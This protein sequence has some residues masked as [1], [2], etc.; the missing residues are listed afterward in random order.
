MHEIR[1]K[2]YIVQP[3]RLK[4]NCPKK[5]IRICMKFGTKVFSMALIR[6]KWFSKLS[7]ACKN[8]K[9]EL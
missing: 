8:A 4:K 6:N 3:A 1:R 2:I 7:D 5:F 9:F